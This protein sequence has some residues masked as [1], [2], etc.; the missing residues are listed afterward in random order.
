MQVYAPPV[1]S[2]PWSLVK[3]EQLWKPTKGKWKRD[4]NGQDWTDN[5]EFQENIVTTGAK[6]VIYL[7]KLLNIGWIWDKLSS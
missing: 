1:N 4:R 5:K 7:K 6:N 3:P 2:H